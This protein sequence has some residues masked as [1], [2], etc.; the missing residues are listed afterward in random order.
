MS[1][2]IYCLGRDQVLCDNCYSCNHTIRDWI[3]CP[4]SNIVLRRSYSQE[5]S[6][7]VI[8]SKSNSE[9]SPGTLQFQKQINLWATRTGEE[10]V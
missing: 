3:E 7:S 5:T 2:R 8:Y 6:S 4:Y 9:Q 10:R 1:P